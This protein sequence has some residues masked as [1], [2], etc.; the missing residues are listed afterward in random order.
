MGNGQLEFEIRVRTA[1]NTNFIVASDKTNVGIRFFNNTL[2]FTIHDARVSTS[3]GTEIQQNKF[4][5]P[6]STKRRL[7]THRDG[8]LST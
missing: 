2:A 6:V 5:D 3:S 7:L 8:D 1:D 4:I